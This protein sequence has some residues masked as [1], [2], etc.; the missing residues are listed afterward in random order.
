[1]S[2]LFIAHPWWYWLIHRK[3]AIELYQ[4]RGRRWDEAL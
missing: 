1:M 3:G 2:D 4:V